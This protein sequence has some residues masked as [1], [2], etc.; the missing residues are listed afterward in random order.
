MLEV[1]FTVCN[2]SVLPAWLL[3]AVAPHWKWTQLLVHSALPMLLLGLT[4][5]VLLLALDGPEGGSFTSLQGVATLLGDPRSALVGWIHYLVFDLFVGA[6]EVRDARRQR[7]RHLFV[8][9]CLALTLMLGPMGLLSYLTLRLVL[10]R[11]A[12][13]DPSLTPEPLE[14]TVPGA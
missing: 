3:L 2:Y 7:I 6:W 13:L 4:Y 5:T 10:R 8:V 14:R 11:Q 9:P 12:S 1:V